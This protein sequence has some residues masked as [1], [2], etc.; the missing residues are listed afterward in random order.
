MVPKQSEI[1]LMNIKSKRP[2]TEDEGKVL[3]LV[4]KIKNFYNE[5]LG[6]NKK[7]DTKKLIRMSRN[8]KLKLIK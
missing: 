5:Y 4:S 8:D 3:L 6:K 7:L 1:I 2:L